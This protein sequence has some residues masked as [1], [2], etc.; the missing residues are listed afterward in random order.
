MDP[1]ELGGPDRVVKVLG[2]MER[3]MNNVSGF[4]RGHARGVAFRGSFEATPQAAALTTAEHLQGE[5]VDCVV[6]VS[7]GGSSPYLPDRE[8]PRRGNTLGIAVRFELA[9]GDHTNWTGLSTQAFPPRTPDDFA[10]MVSAQRAELPGGLPNPLRLLAFLAPRPYALAGIKAAA[11]L[12][13][14]VSFATARFDGLHAFYLVDAA[15]Q[16]RAFRFRWMPLA[17]IQAIDPEDDV[18]LP[19]QY[20]V[21]EMKQRVARAPVAWRLVFQLADR[22]DPTDDVT[23]RWPE[24]R[25][26]VEAG[27]LV[28]DRE[29]ED[30]AEVDAWV[31]DPTR[32][33]PGIE[34]SQDPLLHFRSEAYA[35]SH[36]RRTSETRPA[37]RPE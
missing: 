21:S 9:S 27:Q 11:T 16:R 19:P 30:P 34:L 17:G 12:A 35:E 26:L 14:P 3:H 37:I 15:G 8:T 29:H 13:P 4:K 32:M 24:S 18:N 28:I 36:R 31:F 6:R 33:P 23:R 10:A 25:E 1:H 2:A 22:D 20:L 7:N 5:R